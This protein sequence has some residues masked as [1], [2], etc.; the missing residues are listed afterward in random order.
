[1]QI[2]FHAVLL[3]AKNVKYNY[4]EQHGKPWN[5]KGNCIFDSLVK[6]TCIHFSKQQTCPINY[7]VIFYTYANLTMLLILAVYL[8]ANQ[9][10]LMTKHSKLLFW[11][12]LLKSLVEDKEH[13][14]ML[15]ISKYRLKRYY[16]FI[17]AVERANIYSMDI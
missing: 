13:V 8:G 4:N 10:N 2:T 9:D 6:Q 12:S 5:C 1:M 17:L 3:R 16:L 11:I 14:S 7:D 15:F